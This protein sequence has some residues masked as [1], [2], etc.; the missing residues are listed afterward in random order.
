[1]KQKNNLSPVIILG[2]G[3]SGTKFLRDIL[4][5]SSEVYVIP[6]D[7]GYVWRYRNEKKPHDEL[8]PDMLDSSI[9][10]YIRKTLPSLT[11]NYPKKPR[12]R[13]FIEKSVPNTLRPDFV[14]AVYPEAKF[15]HLIRDG[16]SVTESAMRLWKTP[17]EKSYLLK[18]LRYLPLKNYPYAI[19]YLF[20]QIINKITLGK[21]IPIWGPRY[22]GIHEDLKILPIETI[23]ARQWK[24]CVQN[25]L[26]QLKDLDRNKVIQVRYEDLMRDSNTLESICEFIE[27]KDKEDVIKNYEI[28]VNRTHSKKWI[29]SLDKNQITLINNEIQELNKAV[30][31]S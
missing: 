13:I 2:A 27:I 8:T 5:T 1:M 29:H 26:S 3:R 6:Y 9:I 11:K 22:N 15:I 30:G 28:K 23:C 17:P 16:R 21:S 4:G 25:T 18:K 24:K 10:R 20:N 14:R 31:Y 19:S 7:V 12:A